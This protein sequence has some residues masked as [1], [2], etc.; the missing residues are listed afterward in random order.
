MANTY[1]STCISRH[2]QLINGAILLEQNFT[3]RM[4]LLTAT[5]IFRLN[6]PPPYNYTVS[7]LCCCVCSI[8]IKSWSCWC[9]ITSSPR[10][11]LSV[12]AAGYVAK[13]HSQYHSAHSA[14][15]ASNNSTT[16]GMKSTMST[17]IM[18]CSHS[19]GLAYWNSTGSSQLRQ[20]Q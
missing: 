11:S 15:E 5:S 13:S 4:P 16:L 17:T 1:W 12:S 6:T 20:R 19:D 9:E 8:R 2:S 10:G 7:V 18:H 3:A 14:T